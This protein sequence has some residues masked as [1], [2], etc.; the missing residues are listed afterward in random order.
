MIQNQ[1]IANVASAKIKSF[2]IDKA[3]N[4]STIYDQDLKIDFTKPNAGLVIDGDITDVDTSVVNSSYKRLWAN[5]SDIHSGIVE[6]K[7]S[8]GT[9]IAQADIVPWTSNNLSTSIDLSDLNL[10]T[11][12]TYFLNVCAKTV[13]DYGRIQS[14]AMEYLSQ[15]NPWLI[16]KFK[17]RSL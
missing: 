6:Y 17:H 2:V 11:S 1:S 4:F 10:E 12:Q 14:P 16:F 15:K 13:L 3:N 7:Y 8:L 5:F 9:N